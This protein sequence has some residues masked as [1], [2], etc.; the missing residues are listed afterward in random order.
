MEKMVQL[1][2]HPSCETSE[3]LEQ[4]ARSL[5]CPSLSTA[6]PGKLAE[7]LT[8][9]DDGAQRLQRSSNRTHGLE[10]ALSQERIREL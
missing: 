7:D 9:R 4:S 5:K 3:A 6:A 8:R 2:R 1:Q 10:S